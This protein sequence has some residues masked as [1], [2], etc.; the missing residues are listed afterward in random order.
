MVNK[1]IIHSLANILFIL[2]NI[3]EKSLSTNIRDQNLDT[4][5]HSKLFL[6]VTASL[7]RVPEKDCIHPFWH[8][9]EPFWSTLIQ[10][11]FP[12]FPGDSLQLLPLSTSNLTPYIR[13]STLSMLRFQLLSLA[14]FHCNHVFN[15]KQ[16]QTL[17]Q[18]LRTARADKTCME[19]LGRNRLNAGQDK[20]NSNRKPGIHKILKANS[21]TLSLPIFLL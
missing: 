20:L 2:Q 4:T 18:L 3:T 21:I 1:L 16:N 14:L 11:G 17:I 8:P 15:L 19:K 6:S 12:A 9:H 13:L 5:K 10:E 7:S